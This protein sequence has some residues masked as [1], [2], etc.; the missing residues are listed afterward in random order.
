MYRALFSATEDEYRANDVFSTSVPGYSSVRHL[1]SI[2]EDP[3]VICTP[4]HLHS[5]PLT[6]FEWFLLDVPAR[7][8]QEQLLGV[9]SS[10]ILTIKAF[11]AAG[12]RMDR[13]ICLAFRGPSS[14]PLR[15]VCSEPQPIEFED[16]GLAYELVVETDSV[17]LLDRARAAL[18]ARSKKRG[19]PLEGFD[20]LPDTHQ[21]LN[22][23]VVGILEVRKNEPGAD[24]ESFDSENDLTSSFSPT[25]PEDMDIMAEQFKVES[26]R[27]PEDWVAGGSDFTTKT[28]ELAK[29]IVLTGGNKI[30]STMWL[31]NNG[32]AMH[33]DETFSTNHRTILS[34]F[35]V[36]YKEAGSHLYEKWFP[37]WARMT[38][39]HAHIDDEQVL[40]FAHYLDIS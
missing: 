25:E 19:V 16:Q 28:R 2:G 11:L 36:K 35:G 32:Y 13:R 39:S 9:E 34:G 6:I 26:S 22:S 3:N 8:Q 33:K 27:S 31:G 20:D 10:I 23:K 29:S 30:S 37:D 17:Q 4:G 18:Q 12:A 24:Y 38:T 14:V 40:R 21:S 1:L 7:C 15:A 5:V